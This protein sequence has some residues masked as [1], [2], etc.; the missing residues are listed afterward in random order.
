MGQMWSENAAQ[1]AEKN[2]YVLGVNYAC[3]RNVSTDIIEAHK[4]FNIAALHGDCEAAN[5]R[6]E[7]AAEMSAVE[8]ATAQ[9]RAREWLLVH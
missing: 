1:D 2:F 6:Q 4:W 3:G 7:L 5:R 9:R 8:I